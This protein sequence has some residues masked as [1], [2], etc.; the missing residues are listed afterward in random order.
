MNPPFAK[1][2]LLCMSGPGVANGRHVHEA[3]EP[4]L[5]GSRW[6]NGWRQYGADGDVILLFATREDIE[7][8]M[9]IELD[10]LERVSGRIARLRRL[11]TMINVR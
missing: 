9:R 1:G 5:R 3:G 8:E 7:H 2:D 6:H 11:Q 4:V 10:M